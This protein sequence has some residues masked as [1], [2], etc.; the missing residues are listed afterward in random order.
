MPEDFNQHV[1]D[2]FRANHGAVGGPFEGSRLIL[3]TTTGARTGGPHT[4]P[5][6]FLHD[7]GP[8]ILVI[9]SAAGA[10]HH[11]AWYHN[12]LAD[13]LVTVETGVFTFRAKAEV[14]DPPERDEVFAR[15]VE[16]DPAWAGYQSATSRV[17]PVVALTPVD[18][19]PDA[20]TEGEFLTAIHDAFRRELALIREEVARS[21][22]GSP[23]LGAQLRI[24]CLTLCQG[25]HHHHSA[26]DGGLFP[27]LDE[28]HPELAETVEKLRKEHDTVK[29]LLDELGD[30]IA[31]GTDREV[32]VAGVDRLIGV[33]ETH[34]AHEESELLP[35]LS[36]IVSVPG[37]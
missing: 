17:L 37:G 23:G 4:T 21:S 16:S 2:Q 1:I 18:G 24:N 5:L 14:L 20:A 10:P 28:K 11:P 3:L 29:E 34:L 30:L 9:A 7:D 6:G 32:V 15:A 8:R 12:L 19:A 27:Y 25:L 35:V 22:P 31:N 13:P 33:L 26:E 36:Q